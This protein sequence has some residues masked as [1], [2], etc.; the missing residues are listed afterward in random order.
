[1]RGT[2]KGGRVRG[3]SRERNERWRSCEGYIQGGLLVEDGLH[4]SGREGRRKRTE[5][6]VQRGQREPGA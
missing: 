6:R 4:E 3:F 5:G 2:E 1:M